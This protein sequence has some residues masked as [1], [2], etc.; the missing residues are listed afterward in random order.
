MI[1]RSSRRARGF[2]LIEVL[3]AL[4]I[5]VLTLVFAYRVFFGIAAME[6][7]SRE[8]NA[9]GQDLF[10]AWNIIGQD[11]LHMR[12]RPVRGQL[13][14]LE[15]AYVAGGE[16][17]LVEF[18]RGGLPAFPVSPG[19]LMRVAYRLDDNGD[20]YRVSWQA[21]DAPEAVE[22]EQRLLLQGID[23][24]VV[25]QLGPDN[26]FAQVWPPINQENAPLNLLPRMVRIRLETIDGL[27][28]DRLLPGL[29]TPAF[30]GPGS[31]DRGESGGEDQS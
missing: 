24:F 29:V 18:T 10:R 21:L 6:L 4:L 25:E 12:A 20:L 13:G 15:P 1:F 22:P 16:T 2:T 26:F 23:S 14:A 30:Q 31:G 8:D 17:Y 19:G 11:I 7:R 27:E 5:L 3:V 28:L 9:A